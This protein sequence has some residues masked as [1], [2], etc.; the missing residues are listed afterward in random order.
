MA[1]ISLIMTGLTGNLHA[2]LELASRLKNEGHKITYFAIR[3]VKS[4]TEQYDY[5]YVQLPEIVHSITIEDLGCPKQSSWLKRFLFHKKNKATIYKKAQELLKL[6]QFK[7]II[8]SGK[9]DIVIVDREL[10]EIIFTVQALKI[11]FI[12]ST[13]WF[14]NKMSSQLPPLRTS[15]IPNVGFNGKPPIILIHWY[16]IKLKVIARI[17]LNQALFKDYRRKALLKYAKKNKFP[18]HNI[19][20]SNLPDLFA[21][22]D[23]TTL[24]MTMQEMD[25]KHVPY[26]K[27]H[28]YG[29]MVFEERNK[30]SY[31]E[32]KNHLL[33]LFSE[34]KSNNK[35][36]IL[37]SVSTLVSGDTNF[38]KNLI[39]A[40]AKE[41]NWILIITLGDKIDKTK[42]TSVPEN[43]HLFNWVPQLEILKHADVN[44]NHGGINSINECIHFKVPMLVYSG[45]KFDQNGCAARVHYYGLGIS[46]D[47]DIDGSKEIKEK[48]KKIFSDGAFEKNM[49]TYHEIYLK[50]REKRISDIF[51]LN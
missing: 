51:P 45:K 25:F 8:K 50:Y 39:K 2:S 1:H 17:M 47:K 21:Y 28:Y 15:I 48:L 30:S 40:V 42:F 24:S 34:K 11:P 18:L 37:C 44:I 16:I 38:L 5:N 7:T 27:M 12:I 41:S 19:I 29:P 31:T 49:T 23:L 10:H 32:D 46:G 13:T 43:V 20:A 26:K 3:D 36:L 4:I 35:K 6:N 22:K 14:S 9:P 33:K